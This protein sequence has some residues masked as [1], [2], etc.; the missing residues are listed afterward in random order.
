MLSSMV[1]KLD[2]YFEYFLFYSLPINITA[3]L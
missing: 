1:F 3:C 2:V